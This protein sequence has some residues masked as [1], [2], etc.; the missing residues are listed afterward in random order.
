MP[1]DEKCVK[2]AFGARRDQPLVTRE[3]FVRILH[4]DP[5]PHNSP[6]F[7]LAQVG[8]LAA[9]GEEQ[10]L[11]LRNLLRRSGKLGEDDSGMEKDDEK[12]LCS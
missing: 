1:E 12:G 8:T 7:I 10:F 3:V 6:S 5:E 9:I 2:G 4:A 11:L